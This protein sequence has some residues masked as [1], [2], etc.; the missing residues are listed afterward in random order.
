M[1]TLNFKISSPLFV[2]SSLFLSFGDRRP[3]LGKRYFNLP[4][5]ERTNRLIIKDRIELAV[6]YAQ[7]QQLETFLSNNL[8]SEIE[9]FV[10]ERVFGGRPK[11]S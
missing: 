4:N 11:E 2:S 8:I 9:C 1:G 7:G 5:I 3:L 10:L 6:S